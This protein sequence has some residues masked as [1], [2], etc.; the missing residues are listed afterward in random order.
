MVG[1]IWPN[2]CH[3]LRALKAAYTQM[4]SQVWE[5]FRSG[6]IDAPGGVACIVGTPIG[7]S[8]HPCFSLSEQAVPDVST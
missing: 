3:G 1:S 8:N 2:N 4:Y 7:T 6:L 5:L